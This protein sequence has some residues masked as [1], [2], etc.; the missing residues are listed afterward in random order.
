VEDLIQNPARRLAL[1]QA[2]QRR[3]RNLFSAGVIV[4]LYEAVYGRVCGC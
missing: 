2:A 3:A 1:G 4:P